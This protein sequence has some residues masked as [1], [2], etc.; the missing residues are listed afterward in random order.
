M[1]FRFVVTAI[2]S[3]VF[4]F[5]LSVSLITAGTVHAQDSCAATYRV[6]PGDTLFGIA[7]RFGTSVSELMR[8]NRGRIWNPDLI[9]WGQVLCLPA[10]PTH[11]WLTVE[12]TY[13]YKPNEDE[14]TW[15]LAARGG[16]L[17]KRVVYPLQPIESIFAVSTTE[18]MAMAIDETP[19]PV[20][21]GVRNGSEAITYTLV[22]IGD[23]RVLTSLL[24][25]DVES[26]DVVFPT[27][28]PEKRA[29]LE[30]ALGGPLEETLSAED[31]RGLE[32]ECWG[33]RPVAVLGAELASSASATIWLEGDE[34]VRYPFEVTHVDF[35]SDASKASRCY[36]GKPVGFALFPADSGKVGEYSIR[37]VLT[38]E[39]FGP[40]GLSRILNCQRW[41]GR[42]GWFYRWLRSWYGCPR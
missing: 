29:E 23:E 37:I 15:N 17:G 40:P 2:A 31:L 39:G 12:T 20:L 35:M 25:T 8:L 34:G 32:A 21:L 6:Q 22:A 27:I 10:S 11:S 26:L 36:G 5:L 28:P 7:R 41:Q 9:F 14:S 3:A 42:R 33:S 18:E 38:Q 19:P 4:V 13:Q 1:R 24:I 30:A 16:Y